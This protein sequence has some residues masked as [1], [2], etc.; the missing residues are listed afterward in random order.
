MPVRRANSCG[1]GRELRLASGQEVLVGVPG[2]A[3][4]VD[5]H[6]AL[7][8]C[9]LG[10]VLVLV[11]DEQE[12]GPGVLQDHADVLG[13]EP[14]VERHQHA[15]GGGHAEVG[16]QQRRDVRAE[17]RDPVPLPEPGRPQRRG[18]PVH[19][20]A[21]LPVGV[22]PALRRDGDLVRV[23][24]HAALEEPQRAELGPVGALDVGG[25]AGIAGS[26]HGG[27]SLHR[28][29]RLPYPAPGQ[30]T[31][32]PRWKRPAGR[33]TRPGQHFLDC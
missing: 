8:P 16:L 27:T 6:R 11:I 19:P 24:Q 14:V 15:A 31:R 30:E 9:A 2:P 25:I 5:A 29:R 1:V 12:P 22:A 28:Q 32:H 21:E 33:M 26:G 18:Q 7:G 23:H 3:G 4:V 10:Q 20:L 17:E 13:A